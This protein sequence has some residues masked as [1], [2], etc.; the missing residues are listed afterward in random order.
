MFVKQLDKLKKV[1]D[2]L[3]LLFTINFLLCYHC[4]DG[5]RKTP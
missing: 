5:K 1:Y 4:V 2:I 3:C